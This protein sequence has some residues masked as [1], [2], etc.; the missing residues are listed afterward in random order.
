MK[1]TI[2]SQRRKFLKY[3]AIGIAG[4]ATYPS[5]AQTGGFVRT[6]RPS[7]DFLPDVEI[8]LAMNV[9]DV[10]ILNGEKTRI[11][12][13]TGKVLSGPSTVLDNN[14]GTYLAPTLRFK[15]GQKVRLILNNNLPAQSILHWH[16]LHVP[17][18]MDGNPMYAINRGES[19]IYE[20][21]IL[22]RAGTYF[23]HSHAHGVTARQVYSGLAGLLIVTDDQEQALNLP[24]GELDVPL[25]IQDR[26]FDGQ[27]QL[28]YSGHMMQRMQGFLG[29]H[30]LVNGRPDFVLPVA[31]RAYRFRLVNGSSS[32]IYKL[33]W[34][35]NTPITVI[36][37]DG[38]LLEKP[39]QYPYV[40]LAPGERIDAW[41]DF[42]GRA[43]GTE[44]T[45]RSLKFNA[46]T[47]GGMG[48]MGGGM[49]GGRGH[50]GMMGGG[51]MSVS[52]LPSGSDYPILK[53]RV[54]KKEQGDNI[55]PK[56]LTPITALQ[57][58][59][60]ANAGQPRTIALSMQHMS[61][62]LNGR[63]YKMDD[64]QPDE[65]IPLNSLQLI[66]F[67]NGFGGGGMHGMMNMPHPMHIHGEQFQIVKREISPGFEDSYATVSS[68]FINSG[69]KDTV[70][71]MPGEKV[72]LLKPFNDFKGLFMYHCHNL[73]H[74]D[75]GMM[76]DFL[77]K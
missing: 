12:K 2:N 66:E 14:E 69:W 59:N 23:Y 49:M 47:H 36:G 39:E 58:K 20:F 43:V 50:R 3:A 10:A 77:V 37:V 64:V 70:L 1:T 21:E 25:V 27:N 18:N 24:K 32:R 60:A 53:I 57:A 22:N 30:I 52:T 29:D 40:M 15:K 34:G 42:S 11:W 41:M 76:R 54:A 13:I 16:G 68:G 17:A 51:M 4:A 26:S 65:I 67:D 44:L 63:S 35:D 38:G 9:A 46:S 6:N 61:A 31:T 72:T 28:A 7:D 33:A 74:E 71:V 75:M 73:E 19:Y 8:E 5:W 55:L 56:T 62:L 45:L 48:M